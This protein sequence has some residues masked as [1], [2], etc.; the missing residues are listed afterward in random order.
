MLNVRFVV[1][2]WIQ[3][4][5]HCLAYSETPVADLYEVCG[6]VTPTKAQE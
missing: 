2:N 4:E 5:Y 3:Q 6:V 1:K